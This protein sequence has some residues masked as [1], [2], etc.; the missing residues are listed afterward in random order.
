MHEIHLNV[1]IPKTVRQEWAHITFWDK[2]ERR[3]YWISEVKTGNLQVAEEKRNT[4]REHP[5]RAP[6]KPWGTEGA[7]KG[8]GSKVLF[9]SYFLINSLNSVPQKV[10][11]R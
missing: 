4:Q 7:G 5:F 2:G 11:P 8:G 3:G 10:A 9:E 6:Q 1:K